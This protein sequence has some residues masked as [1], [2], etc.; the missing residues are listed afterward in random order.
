MLFGGVAKTTM[1]EA[2]ALMLADNGVCCIDEFDK[3]DLTDQVAIHEAMEQQTISIAKQNV[4]LSA[5]IMSRFDLFF[6]LIDECSE[7]VDYAI[8]RKIVDLHC[9]KEEAYDCL[10][11][12]VRLAEGMAKMHCSGHVTPNHVMEA[13]RYVLH[14]AGG[15]ANH[16]ASARVHGAARG[17]HGQDALQRARHSQ[18]RHGGVQ[19]LYISN[20]TSNQQM[21]L[22]VSRVTLFKIQMTYW[23]GFPAAYKN[24]SSF[25]GEE[26]AGMHKSAVVSWYL[27]QLVAQGTIEDEDELLERKTLVEKVIDRLMYHSAVVSWY[28]EQLVAQGSIEDEDELLERKTLVERVIDRLMYHSAVVSWYL[29]QL[30]AQGSIEDEDELLE[31]KTLVERVIGRLMYHVSGPSC[32][33][34]CMSAVV[35]WYL[36]QVVAQ[37]SI[38][39]EDELLERKT[40]VERVIDRLMYHVS[41]PSCTIL[42]KSAV[43]SW[44]LEQLVAQGSIEDEDELLERKTLVERVID[45]LMYHDQVIIP[46]STTGLKASQR[47]SEQEVED[48]P[49]LVVHPNYVV[50]TNVQGKTQFSGKLGYIKTMK[51]L[52]ILFNLK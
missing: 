46:L 48:D 51:D 34:L 19:Q 2:G 14:G 47:S 39:D 1:E 17:G 18:P 50:D 31:R 6:I 12:M 26:S 29:E 4:A 35:S 27:E 20:T 32:T 8:A 7:M 28:L 41:G 23:Q 16:G 13:Y 24:V 44:Y 33:I 21:A 25:A 22:R 10:E 49:L 43:V 9:N 30:V 45:R 40:L 38:E 36:E 11:S 37:G 52:F 15:V 42:C 3:M 5:P